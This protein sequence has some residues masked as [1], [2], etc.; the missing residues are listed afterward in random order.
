MTS[1]VVP[2]AQI[3]LALALF[4]VALLCLRLDKKLT[5][6]RKGKD[7]VAQTSAQLSEVVSRAEAAIVA[8]RQASSQ[9]SSELQARVDEARALYDGLR[10]LTTT[11]RALEAKPSPTE[12]APEPIARDAGPQWGDDDFKPVRRSPAPTSRWESLR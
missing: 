2:I 7:G 10:F 5:A 12:R 8:L 4:W 3:M 9:A 6:L 11:A 1:L